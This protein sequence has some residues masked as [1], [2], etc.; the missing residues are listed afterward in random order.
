MFKKFLSV[1]FVLSA[2]AGARVCALDIKP[3]V[4]P[5]GREVTISAVQ[6]A[7]GTSRILRHMPVCA[8]AFNPIHTLRKKNACADAPLMQY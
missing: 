8:V 5:V 2:S 4:I 6:T 7:L 1:F 3:I